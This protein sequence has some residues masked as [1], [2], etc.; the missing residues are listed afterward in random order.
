MSK[1]H[2]GSTLGESNIYKKSKKGILG[3]AYGRAIVIILL[4]AVQFIGIFFSFAYFERHL[5]VV[6]SGFTIISLIMA[7]YIANTYDNPSIKLSWTALV[8][9]AP[10]FGTL[11]YIFVHAEIG[12]R[13][14][15]RMYRSVLDKTSPCLKQNENLAEQLKL[16]E[17]ELYNTSNYTF[18]NGGYPVYTNSNT[19]YFP[20]GKL[21]WEKMLSELEKA[22]DFIFLEYFIIEE[23]EMWGK[24]LDILKKKASQGVEVRVIYDGTCSVSLLPH[25]YPKKLAA[26]GIKCRV[27]SPLR[28][29]VST[30]YNNRDHRKILVIDGCVAFTGGVNLADEYINTKKRFGHWKDCGIMISGEAVKSFTLMFLQI[31]N[32]SPYK[33][34]YGYYLG[35]SVSSNQKNNDG[36]II[37]YGDSPLDHEKVGETVYMDMINTA[38]EYIYI[39]TPYLIIDNEMTTALKNAAKRGVDVRIII[40]HIPDHK[41]A[42]AIS[43]THCNELVPE[44]VQIYEYL[45]GF[46]HS[47]VFISDSLRAVVGSINLDY[48]SLYLHFECAAYIYKSSVINDIFKDFCNTFPIC[49]KIESADLEKQNIFTHMK[50]GLLKLIAPLI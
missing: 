36:Y 2:L 3:I 43:K 23:G 13:V 27:F 14:M 29:F 42:Y 30:H 34:N 11:L 31:W 33:E 6:F 45:P 48:R 16:T 5:S 47:K 37:P 24:I 7:I 40:P 50:S 15:N 39:M 25:S 35:K 28:P 8:L 32:I 49:K 46:I 10:V 21:L 20:D 26:C 41:I 22:R 38:K 19:K 44:G 4:L 18:A 9:T 1:K 12:H 17:R